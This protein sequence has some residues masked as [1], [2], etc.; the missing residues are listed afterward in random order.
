M[1]YPFHKL[2]DLC[3]AKS[4]PGNNSKQMQEEYGQEYVYQVKFKAPNF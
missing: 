2:A 1:F 3:W 4:I